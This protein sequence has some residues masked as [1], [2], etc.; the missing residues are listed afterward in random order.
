[1]TLHDAESLPAGWVSVPLGALVAPSPDRVHPTDC[2][3]APF[4]SLEHIESGTHRIVGR[5]LATDVSSEKTPFKAGD[6]LYGRLR[7]YLNKV[8]IPDFDGICS[9]DILV[10]PQTDGLLNQY[11]LYFLSQPASVQYATHNATGISLPRVSFQKLA[12]LHFPLP[13]LAEQQ[14]IVNL[15][16]LLLARI[17]AVD[18]TLASIPGI[19][20]HIHELVLYAACSGFLT[21]QW[22]EQSGERSSRSYSTN[23]VIGTRVPQNW[24]SVTLSQATELVTSG[25]RDWSAYYSEDGA[26]FIRSQNIRDDTLDLADVAHVRPPEGGEGSRTRV[27][28]SD[29]LLTITGAN[30][31]K[32]AIVDQDLP[33]AYVNQHVALIRLNEPEAV[34]FLHLWTISPRNG[35]RYLSDA[36]YGGG[37]PGLSLGQVRNMPIALPPINE[38]R[39][40]V[41]KAAAFRNWIDSV[42]HRVNQTRQVVADVTGE[43]FARACRGELVPQNPGEESAGRLLQN[44][45]EQLRHRPVSRQISPSR[46]RSK[47]STKP[48][49]DVTEFVQRLGARG[50]S[51]SPEQLLKIAGLGDDIDLFFELLRTARDMELLEIPTGLAGPIRRK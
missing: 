4:V 42:R 41:S 22:R 25:S 27:R 32:S 51:A 7:P 43:V 44:I 1:M 28:R 19:L 50:E 34:H 8:C 36:A 47:M 12:E 3:D 18:E 31:T 11:L 14:R 35:R 38:Q 15:V 33:E 48:V 24:H 20:D 10:F 37:K 9:T 5:G 16:G 45:K 21:E 49:A 39:V 6:V 46:R 29:M 26:L 23:H 17:H 40:I 13:P 2:P 30:V